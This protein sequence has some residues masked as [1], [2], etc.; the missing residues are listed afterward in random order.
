MAYMRT[1][2]TYLVLTERGSVKAY[3]RGKPTVR[4]GEVCVKVSLELPSTLFSQPAIEAKITVPIDSVAVKT[5]SSV[6]IDK[7]KSLIEKDTGLP[8]RIE[9]VG[10][11][12][13]EERP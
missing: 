9:L 3:T 8:V 11:P 4:P 10:F 13:K 5:V 7:V 1:I 2:S 12:D 6:A